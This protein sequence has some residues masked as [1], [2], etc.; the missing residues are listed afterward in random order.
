MS[1]IGKLDAELVMILGPVGYFGAV[2]PS[3][4]T[5]DE[6]SGTEIQQAVLILGG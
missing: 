4:L 6:R 1:L 2:M 3:M 5:A